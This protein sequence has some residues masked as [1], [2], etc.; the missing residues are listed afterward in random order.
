MDDKQHRATTGNRIEAR[1][2]PA[3]PAVERRDA[4][5]NHGHGGQGGG[6][7]HG[8]PEVLESVS[9]AIQRTYR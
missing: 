4:D 6:A 5:P 8:S 1:S 7:T 9:E 2:W 3:S